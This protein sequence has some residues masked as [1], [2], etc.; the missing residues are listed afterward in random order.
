MC[1]IIDSKDKKIIFKN[2]FNLNDKYIKQANEIANKFQHAVNDNNNK[3]SFNL[4][5]AISI[6]NNDSAMSIVSTIDQTIYQNT[7][8]IILLINKFIEVL[9]TSLSVTLSIEDINK[10]KDILNDAFSNLN[11]EKNSNWIFFKDK[12][13]NKTS[14]Q[15]NILFATNT[16]NNDIIALPIGLTINVNID[17]EEVLFIKL[18]DKNDYSIDIQALEISESINNKAF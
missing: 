2:I 5:Q 13:A 10:F 4:D 14:Y 8:D 3:L 16:L 9:N 6:A 17:E 1:N 12:K 15:Y 7:F 11:K 18:K